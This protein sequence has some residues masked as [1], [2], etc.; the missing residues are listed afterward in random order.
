M[1]ARYQHSHRE[2]ASCYHKLSCQRKELEHKGGQ[3]QVHDVYCM[4]CGWRKGASRDEV[5]PNSEEIKPVAISIVELC[6]AGEIS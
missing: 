1:L 2:V 5:M 6:L 3:R 4:Y